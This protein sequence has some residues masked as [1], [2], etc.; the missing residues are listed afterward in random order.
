MWLIQAFGCH[1]ENSNKLIAELQKRELPYTLCG[2]Q[3]FS[4]EISGLEDLVVERALA[5]GSTK[6]V[7]LIQH[8][9]IKPGVFFDFSSFNVLAWRQLAE[10]Y[11]NKD[12]IVYNVKSLTGEIYHDIFIR[13]VMDLKAFAGTIALKGDTWEDFFS[14]TFK[15]DDYDKGQLVAIRHPL[16][17]KEEQRFFI[18]NRKIVAHSRYKLNGESSI[19]PR[20]DLHFMAYVQNYVRNAWLPNETCVIDFAH[21]GHDYYMLEFNCFNCSGFY[22][23]DVGKIVEAIQETYFKD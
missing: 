21:V 20:I 19:S 23:A 6:F 4:T 13:P 14:R 3:P 2:V 22:A 8:T 1:S 16:K 11:L 9:G 17:I 7:S 5:Y 15:T 10:D 18:V 12:S